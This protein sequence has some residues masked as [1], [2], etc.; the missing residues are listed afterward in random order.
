MVSITNVEISNFRNIKSASFDLSNNLSNRCAVEG[1]NALGKTNVLE[2]I[3]FALTNYLLDGSSDLK[4]IKPKDDMSAKVSVKLTFS[5]EKTFEKV[6][7]ENWVK[8]RG[9]E[10]VK[11]SGHTTEYYVN[12]AKVSSVATAQKQL[13]E[14]ILEINYSPKTSKIDVLQMQ[15]NPLWLFKYIDWS[16]LRKY[17]IELVG[18]VSNEEVIDKLFNDYEFLVVTDV[19]NDLVKNSYKTD[20]VLN[21]YKSGLNAAKQQASVYEHSISEDK[22]IKNIDENNYQIALENREKLIQ[23]KQSLLNSKNSAVNPLVIQYEKEIEDLKGKYNALKEK[24]LEEY[25][26]ASSRLNES[27]KEAREKYNITSESYE[28]SNNDVKKLEEELSKNENI[29]NNLTNDIALLDTKLQSLRKKYD[30]VYDKTF[31]DAL[32]LPEELKCPHCGGVVNESYIQSVKDDYEH[33]KETF[34]NNISKELNSISEEAFMTK[35]SIESKKFELDSLNLNI[36]QISEEHSKLLDFANKCLDKKNQS[37][38]L[39]NTL[40]SQLKNFKESVDVLYVKSQIDSLN[41]RLNYEKNKVYSNP[42]IDVKIHEINNQ[43]A[44]VEKI[45]DARKFYLQIQQKISDTKLKLNVE[46]SKI[47]DLEAKTMVVEQFIKTKLSMLDSNIA[48]VFDDIE[49]VLVS[50]NIKDGSWN[51]ECYP[52]IVGTKT[53]F[54]NGSRSEQY[55][56]AIKIVEKIKNLV[57]LPDIPYLI[58]EAG[59]FDSNTIT[60][61]LVTNSQIIASRMNDNYKVITVN[62]L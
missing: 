48:A 60:N 44:E 3:C 14:D 17:I 2:A 35:A 12:G 34:E 27:I 28:H 40:Q 29:K 55:V 20:I 10:E 58:D 7:F 4:S 30:Q 61:K 24:E 1:Q 9:T 16:L 43:I 45:I 54:E 36:C 32:I 15:V 50:S 62:E 47:N 52:L 18:D 21:L 31:D 26:K 13:M 56:T 23:E 41:D 33:R 6:Y 46:L 25:S 22:K 8:T 51:Q 42:E 38:A 49:F 11:L 19:K 39:L 59:T 53:P 57:G 37:L 5:N